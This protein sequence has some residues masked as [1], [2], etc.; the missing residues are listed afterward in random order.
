MKKLITFFFATIISACSTQP[1]IVKERDIFVDFRIVSHIVCG[2]DHYFKPNGE[3]YN[4]T[5]DQIIT[6]MAKGEI[7]NKSLSENLIN[8]V[9]CLN[10]AETIAKEKNIYTVTDKEAEILFSGISAVLNVKENKKEL[11]EI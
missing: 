4:S 7:D 10:L 1:H 6:T 5:M 11:T 2:G 3:S 9:M 8:H